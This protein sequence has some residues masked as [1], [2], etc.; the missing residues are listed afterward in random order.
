MRI[1]FTLR[2]AYY[3]S[4]EHYSKSMLENKHEHSL[5]SVPFM[6]IS[7]MDEQTCL[8]IESD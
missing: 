1:M 4:K 3:Q 5:F 8:R 6:Q 2:I 7:D